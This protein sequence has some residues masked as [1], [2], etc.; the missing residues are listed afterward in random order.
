[1]ADN[2]ASLFIDG[3]WVPAASGATRTITCPADGTT[4]DAR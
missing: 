2:P 4:V 1:M 3:S